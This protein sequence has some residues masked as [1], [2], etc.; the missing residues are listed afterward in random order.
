MTNI[1][2][3]FMLFAIFVWGWTGYA[4]VNKGSIVAIAKEN[5]KLVEAKVLEGKIRR[6]LPVGTSLEKTK[7]YLI[8]NNSEF[9]IFLIERNI[10]GHESLIAP[11]LVFEIYFDADLR[12]SSIK[13]RVEYTGP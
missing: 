9:T 11:S 2:K 5:E 13:S 10:K 1:A 12:I 7:E 4:Y 6:D 3:M 8:K